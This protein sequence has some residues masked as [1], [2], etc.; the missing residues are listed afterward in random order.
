LEQLLEPLLKR[1]L[2]KLLP[3]ILRQD[4]GPRLQSLLLLLLLV[5]VL[6]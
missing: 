3:H 2:Q 4:R 5:L 1:P 6:Q